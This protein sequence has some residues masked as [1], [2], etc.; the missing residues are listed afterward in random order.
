MARAVTSRGAAFYGVSTGTPLTPK[1]VAAARERNGGKRAPK[2]STVQTTVASR[3]PA[4]RAR[5]AAQGAVV[6]LSARPASIAV[7]PQ[8]ETVSPALFGPTTVKVENLSWGVPRGALVHTLPSGHVYVLAPDD[9]AL[10]VLVRMSGQVREI[11]MTRA[12]AQLAGEKFRQRYF[13]NQ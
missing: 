5:S 2:G 4:P 7:T 1:I 9:P 8:P 11:V 6:S 12:M 3:E 10:H 13:P